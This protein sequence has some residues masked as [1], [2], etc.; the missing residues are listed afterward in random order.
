M[1]SVIR[2]NRCVNIPTKALYFHDTI[3]SNGTAILAVIAGN[4]KKDSHLTTTM[5]KSGGGRRRGRTAACEDVTQKGNA[6]RGSSNAF[7][8]QTDS[9]FYY[10]LT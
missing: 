5:P 6:T 8:N 2:L 4:R 7:E 9:D 10:V 3:S 1:P